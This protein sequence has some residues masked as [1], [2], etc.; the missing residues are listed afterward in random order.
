MV[1]LV[2]VSL[3]LLICAVAACSSVIT[4]CTPST[5]ERGWRAALPPVPY[6]LSP[7]VLCTPRETK[8]GWGHGS[9][10]AWCLRGAVV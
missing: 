6:L 1:S 4:L 10:F 9:V 2:C 5:V 7:W 3:L 8:T